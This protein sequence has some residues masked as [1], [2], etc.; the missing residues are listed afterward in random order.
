MYEITVRELEPYTE[1][2]EKNSRNRNDFCPGQAERFS[3]RNYHEKRMLN[4]HL[5][6]EEFQ[7]V[8]KAVISVM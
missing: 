7:E 2:E 3:D 8:K 1:E 5:T 4:V 6:E